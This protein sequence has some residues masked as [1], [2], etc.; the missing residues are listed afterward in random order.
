MNRIKAFIKRALE[1]IFLPTHKKIDR[2]DQLSLINTA[3]SRA[4]ATAAAR[5]VEP[6]NPLSWEF[7]GFSQNGEDGLLD[8]LTRKLK[9]S[10]RYFIEIGAS[11]GIENNTAWFAHGRKFSGLMIDGNKQTVERGQAVANFGT[12]LRWLF[13]NK[14]NISNLHD[15]AVHKN[16]DIF[17]LDIDGIDYYMAKSILEGG[18]RPKIFIVEYNS[19]FGPVDSKTV[20]YR[21]DFR[22]G[23]VHS[24]ELY[25]GVSIAGWK[26]FFSSQG[27]KFITVDS[28]G[29]NAIFV[30]PAEFDAGFLSQLKGLDFAENFYQLKKFKGGWEKQSALISD[31]KYFTIN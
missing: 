4:A 28:N 25:Y 5:V 22:M 14:D 30:D 3:L 18:F 13:V 19:A 20:E 16:P 24:T 12:D 8:Y 31:V 6:A 7:S 21:Q 23:Q 10:N 2:L 17:S 1:R 26:T 15:L 27:Y 9:N 29:V 11:G